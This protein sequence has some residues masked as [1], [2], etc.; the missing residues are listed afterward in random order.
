MKHSL[1][2]ANKK[3][4]LSLI[5]K[6]DL[7]YTLYQY[8]YIIIKKHMNYKYKYKNHELEVQVLY[9]TK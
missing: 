5:R 7:I 4:A 3:L 8:P 1:F 2:T 6:S 9:N